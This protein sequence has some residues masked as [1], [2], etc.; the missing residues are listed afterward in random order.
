MKRIKYLFVAAALSLTVSSC[1]DLEHEPKGLIY[2]NGLL[3]SDNGIKKYFA[4]VYQDLPI[5]DF[6]YKQNGDEKG[7]ATVNQAGWHSGNKWQA[8]K[9]SPAAAACE[10][11]GRDPS[12]GDGW[13]YWPYDR[14]RD[15]NYFIEAFPNYQ[16]YY[17]EEQYN[18]HL[19]EAYFLR[20]F[21]YF[22]LVKR[23]GGVPIVDK[24]LDPRT[25]IEELQQP[26][27]TEYDCWKFIYED[28][29]FAMENASAD[30]KELGRANRYA[31]AA[32]MSRAMI[33]AGSIAKYGGYIGTTGPAVSAGLMGMPA[34]K[35]QEFFQY[36]YDAGQYLKGAGY[37]L[38]TGADKEKAYTEVFITNT[39]EDIL[40][41]QYGPKTTTPANTSLFHCWDT[42]I[43]PVGEGLASAVGAA[44]Q[45]AW[46]IIG[47]YDMP[48][49]IDEDGKPV[50]FDKAEDIWN[51]DEMEA[52]ARAN[53]FF[54]GMTESVSGIVMDIQGGV[55][56]EYPGLAIDGTAETQGSE[57]EY[58]KQYRRR[59]SQPGETIDIN[60]Q[61]IPLNGKHG[62]AE[63]T[64]DEGYTR[65]GAFIRKYI[66]YTA[67]ASSRA[68]FGSSQSWKVFRYGEILCNQA[69][70]AYELGLITN[71][72]AL[73]S[74][75]FEYINELRE[76]AGAKPHAM[77]TNPEDIGSAIYGFLIDE[78]LQ[79]IRDERARELCYENHRL[80]DLRRW[81]V[82]DIMFQNGYWPHTLLSYYV[83]SEG[84]YIYLNEVEREGRKVTFEKR[85][86]YE[87]IPGGEIGKNPNLIR[88]D[89][90]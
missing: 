48:A 90:Y 17:T 66:D 82:A 60:G 75:A 50:R 32:L 88:N 24:V 84:K 11:A 18:S 14:I 45:P 36:A 26:R 33:Y 74:E 63:G 6:N 2:E 41:K 81:R 20:A 3:I 19:G 31:A 21:Y 35:A 28:L 69:E 57:N 10:A 61:R 46:E 51:T 56:T 38:H 86:Y 1:Y 62:L 34:D 47:L 23:Y 83:A 40:I 73:K 68:L 42:M 22:G 16:Q 25:P 59:A 30:K 8:Q 58:T 65:T 5:E 54:S 79:Y 53:F 37:S 52:R 85:W 13:G 87:Q 29:K 78:N 44:L 89:G 71:N 64:G 12:Y 43:L 77:V 49:I 9:G 67:P 70:A 80:Y 72:E 4:L 15:I 55:Y 76:R 27:D 7:Y 39:N